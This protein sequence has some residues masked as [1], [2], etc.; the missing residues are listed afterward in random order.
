[1]LM[2]SEKIISLKKLS[3]VNLYTPNFDKLIHFYRDVLGLNAFPDNKGNWFGF[4]TGE[5]T[6][7]LEPKENRK[8][9]D[10]EFN[11]DNPILLQFCVDSIKELEMLTES[12]EKKGVKIKQ[13]LQKKNYGTITTFLDSDNNVI[14]LLVQEK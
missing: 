12:L 3:F 5:T 6:F 10:F 8:S 7:A 14:E 9:Y 2:D 11:K 13:K 1:M 4:C